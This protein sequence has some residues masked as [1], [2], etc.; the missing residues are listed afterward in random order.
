[1]DL[2]TEVGRVPRVDL[3]RPGRDPYSEP[4]CEIAE[5]ILSRVARAAECAVARSMR[6]RRR[7]R[8]CKERWARLR[9]I[10]AADSSSG[11]AGETA[12]PA[13]SCID[14]LFRPAVRRKPRLAERS[15][16]ASA[17][18]AGVVAGPCGTANPSDAGNART[19]C[20]IGLVQAL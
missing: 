18:K 14:R 15:V 5:S 8:C 11:L 16:R 2:R 3:P 1:M 7:N 10:A 17:R 19:K 13:E 9:G 12:F 20:C 4:R 6:S